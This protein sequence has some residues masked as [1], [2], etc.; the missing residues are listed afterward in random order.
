MAVAIRKLVAEF[1]FA[2]LGRHVPELSSK[3]ALAQFGRILSL[4]GLNAI[5]ALEPRD[6]NSAPP[7]T[8]SGNYGRGEFPLH[9]DLAHWY[10]PP[11]YLVLRCVAGLK[12]VATRVLDG[13]ELIAAL[14]NSV[15]QRALVQPRRPLDNRRVLLRLLDSPSG[16]AQ[17]LRWNRLFIV[18]VTPAAEMTFNRLRAYTELAD[19]TEVS[20][21]KPGDTL[22]L[23][24]WR[25]LHGRSAAGDDGPQRRI[26]RA[27]FDELI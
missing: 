12:G 14:G 24:N 3:E 8:Y 19:V 16:S 10:L 22:V 7:N 20:L 1:G 5:Q 6:T 21:A 18:P 23:D 11:R 26:E 4:P 2:F 17:L 15:L 25:M 9:T 27:Y 13:K